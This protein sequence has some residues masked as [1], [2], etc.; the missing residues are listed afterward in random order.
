MRP[1]VRSIRTAT[2]HQSSKRN[3]VISIH[4]DEGNSR[5]IR[6]P[7]KNDPATASTN[8]NRGSLTPKTVPAWCAMF[9]SGLERHQAV[10]REA[11]LEGY[12]STWTKVTMLKLHLEETKRPIS[13]MTVSVAT[14]CTPAGRRR[15]HIRPTSKT[16]TTESGSTILA[17]SAH[18]AATAALGT[19][20]RRTF[21][22]NRS[23]RT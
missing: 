10:E 14:T 20:Q 2:G 19:P 1:E 11:P 4:R 5:T 15:G 7:R 9:P 21:I 22:T 8:S 18:A 13:D 17:V 6:K 16:T 12:P 3:T 23:L